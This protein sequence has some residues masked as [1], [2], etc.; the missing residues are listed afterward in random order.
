MNL[1]PLPLTQT[2]SAVS[3]VSSP[4]PFPLL[5]CL[6][7]FYLLFPLLIEDTTHPLPFFL[8]K[9]VN[10]F[11]TLPFSLFVSHRFCFSSCYPLRCS[12][13]E[14]LTPSLGRPRRCRGLLSLSLSPSSLSA[15]L[16][17]TGSVAVEASCLYISLS[18]SL[19][20]SLSFCLSTPPPHCAALPPILAL[21]SSHSLSLL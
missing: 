16:R 6:Q 17:L 14:P 13:L 15:C 10:D 21:S 20:H 19:S 18:L 5:L 2:L 12:P 1:L 9:P 7:N 8:L 11:V 4:F 3:S